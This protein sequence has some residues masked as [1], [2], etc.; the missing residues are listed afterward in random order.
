MLLAETRTL[1]L[2]DVH[3]SVSLGDIIAAVA[4]LLSGYA[5][6][7]SHRFKSKEEDLFEVQRKV[8]TL[9]LEKE[10]REAQQA[11]RAELGANFVTFGSNNH[12][13]KISNKGKAVAHQV[14]IDF[15]DGNDLVIDSDIRDK[16][17]VESFEP[18]QSVSLKAAIGFRMTR[19]LAIRL[20]WQD[21]DGKEREK[22]VNANL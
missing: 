6:W 21:I 14:Q 3:M 16:F 4:L 15:P 10:E 2:N 20:R 5:T 17:P 9:V 13:L 8:N 11:S 19:K 18:G 7:R 22:V 1:R 12:C